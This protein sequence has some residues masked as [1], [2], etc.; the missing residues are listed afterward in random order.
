MCWAQQ[1]LVT[2]LLYTAFGE[3]G[4]QTDVTAQLEKN[5]LTFEYSLAMKKVGCLCAAHPLP[6]FSTP[7]CCSQ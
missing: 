3:A 1:L 6:I 4:F 2:A 5:R 7:S